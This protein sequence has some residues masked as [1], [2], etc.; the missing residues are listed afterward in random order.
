MPQHKKRFHKSKFTNV[1]YVAQ[2]NKNEW[3][4]VTTCHFGFMSKGQFW[5]IILYKNYLQK[6]DGKN[7]LI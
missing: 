7:N 1:H 3:K 4:N 2:Q 5:D 6:L